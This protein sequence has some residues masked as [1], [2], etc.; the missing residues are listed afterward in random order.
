VT[1]MFV[2]QMAQTDFDRARR[3]ALRADVLAALVRRPNTLLSYHAV[4]SQFP[5]IGTSD[6][7][8]RVVPVTHIV[9]SMDRAGDFD[10]A[11]R[12]R[13]RHFADR[14]KRVARASY[15]GV[16]LPPVRLVRVADAYF[17]VDGHHRVSVARACGQQFV[18]A[19]VVEE[20]VQFPR[21]G[22]APATRQGW[23][24]RRYVGHL[25][26]SAEGDHGA[27]RMTN[28]T[29]FGWTSFRSSSWA[30]EFRQ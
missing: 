17:V 2:D 21:D 24:L 25:I 11:F 7:G 19:E 27:K 6:L 13:S 15:E 12:P 16:S 3:G 20:V 23:R 30:R 29:G 14:W 4:R 10:R 28:R 18:D 8:L 26:R 1:R 22:A 5:P 9:G